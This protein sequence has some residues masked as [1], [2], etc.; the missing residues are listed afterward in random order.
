[1]DIQVFVKRRK[2]L[3]LSQIE[4]SQGICTQATLSRFEN[5]GQIPSMKILS[6]LCARLQLDVGDLFASVNEKEAE[7]NKVLEKIEQSLVTMD[8]ALAETL[9]ASIRKE[10]LN[11][12]QQLYLLY[13]KGY[14]KTLQGKATNDDLFYFNQLLAENQEQGEHYLHLAYA[15]LGLVYQQHEDIEKAT[16]F[17][18]KAIQESERT[19]L[20]TTVQVWRVLM[21]LY[22]S[23]LFFAQIQQFKKS[24]R[25]LKKGIEICGQYHITYYLARM[26]YQLA[27]N[28]LDNHAPAGQAREL[29]HD[30]AAFA[31]I[32]AN[33]QLLQDV[34][35]HM[36]DLKKAE[37]EK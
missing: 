13:L 11:K 35:G 16:Y 14:T 27:V 20:D 4:L 15:G 7:T 28:A 29:L 19:S 18:D 1:M 21:V 24:D 30:A 31:R 22:Y 12:D 36:Q 25:L 8:Y 10:K 33:E 34:E 37:K 2:E 3:G 6:Q 9:T 26:Y 23:A 17:F 5:H 32:N